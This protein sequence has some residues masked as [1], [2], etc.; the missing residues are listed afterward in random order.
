MYD[1]II[2]GGGPAG[3]TCGIYAKRSGLK[4]LLIEKNIVGG[5]VINTYEIKN[6]PTYTNISGADFC[7]LLYSQA[8]YNELEI[9]S[10]EVLKTNL[11][12]EIKTIKTA[13]N[14]YQSKSV[15]ICVGAQPRNLGLENES[16]LIG[17]GISYCALCDGN[18]FKNK[19]VA[20][21][22]GGDSAMEDAIYLGGIC[23]K[24]YVVNRSNSLRAQKVLQGS[25]NMHIKEKGNIEIIYNADVV[26]I[27]G[28]N[29]LTD[30]D[31]LDKSKNQTKN[32]K[33][34]GMFLAI[35]RD[36]D[37][38]IFENE[39]LLTSH[40]Y[41]KVDSKLQTNIKG[42]FA[43]GDC[44][45]KLIRQILTACSDGAICATN[46]NNFIKGE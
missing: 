19:T 33:V 15:V 39:I 17:K 4:T 13:K 10:E 31:I 42:V 29:F 9:V 45:E 21:I 35:G 5:Q 44:I 2:I 12:G 25:L 23:E 37:T 26:K 16:N 40:G 14:E 43:G 32:L 20:V 8:E 24:V 1:L 30:I 28:D 22:G 46:A 38:K 11:S 36:P 27:N 41:I 18:F 6:F 34:D 3:I 7:G